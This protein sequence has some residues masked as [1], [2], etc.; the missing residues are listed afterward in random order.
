MWSVVKSPSR[1]KGK[2]TA[3]GRISKNF[4][5]QDFPGPR[6][7]RKKFQNS[8]GGVE[9]LSKQIKNNWLLLVEFLKA[10]VAD[11]DFL[12]NAKLRNNRRLWRAFVAENLTTSS[13]MMLPHTQMDR[14]I[15]NIN[16]FKTSVKNN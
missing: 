2:K 14:H 1:V 6:K 16:W 11:A 4:I 9:T 10:G 7:S 5:F 8:S 3:D 13:T 15:C 12:L